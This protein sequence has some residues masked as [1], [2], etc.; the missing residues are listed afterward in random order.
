MTDNSRNRLI[1]T[2]SYDAGLLNNEAVEAR[3]SSRQRSCV[4]PFVVRPKYPYDDG[5]EMVSEG[6][7]SNWL[8]FFRMSSRDTGYDPS[9]TVVP[10]V[11][12]LTVEKAV[13]SRK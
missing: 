9:G 12:T 6:K 7:Y 3:Q 2:I 8:C 10:R 11:L 13:P 5:S 4:N 1:C